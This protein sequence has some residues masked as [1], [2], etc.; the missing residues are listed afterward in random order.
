MK[1][2]EATARD[3]FEGRVHYQIPAYQRPYVW[4]EEDQWSPLWTDVVRVATALLPPADPRAVSAHFLGAVVIEPR[5]DEANYSRNFVIDGQQRMTTMQVLLD[6]VQHV[7]DELGHHQA[8]EDL[9]ELVLNHATRYAGKPERFKLWPSAADR[10]SFEGAM[11]PATGLGDRGHNIQLAHEFFRVEARKWITGVENEE[12]S[13]ASPA[14]RATAL[15]TALQSKLV[16]IAI[17]LAGSD[18]PQVIFET[19]NDRGTPLLKA[20]LIK[21]WV[22][23]EGDRVGADV[24]TWPTRFWSTFDE[25]WWRDEIPQGRRRRSRIDIFLQYWL[26]M[27]LRRDVTSDD[28]FRLFRSHASEAFQDILT[29]EGFLAELLRDAQT[30]RNF[31]EFSPTSAAGRFFSR[32]VET[33]E[34]GATSPVLLWFLSDNHG[35]PESQ[36]EIGLGSLESWVVRRTLTR[37]TMKGVNNLMVSALTR[38]DAAGP[39]QAGSELRTFL[40]EQSAD[41]RDWPTD[42]QVI[43]AVVSLPVYG[44]IRQ[45]RVVMLLRSVERRLV[46]SNPKVEDVQIVGRF[47]LEHV[48]PRGWRT[49][50]NAPPLEQ[51]DASRRD[52]LIH[53]LGN[54]TLVTSSLNGSLS[55]R[56]WN[57]SDADGLVEGGEPNRGKRS[58][59]A[60]FSTLM[61]NKEI[62]DGHADSWTNSDIELRSRLLATRIVEL[63]SGPLE[64]VRS[65]TEDDG[66][67]PA[68]DSGLASIPWTQ[69]DVNR[70]AEECGEATLAV[71]DHLA[72]H[73]EEWFTNQGLTQEI[74]L[75]RPYAAVGALTNK[76]RGS[77]RR[78]NGP[79]MFKEGM[80]TWAWQVDSAFAEQW[81]KARSRQ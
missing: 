50:W 72:D 39:D 7:V 25:T 13:P 8:A 33:L 54:L 70:L 74:G 80:G 53:T 55:N 15:A 30:F 47:E 81:R 73:A 44:W 10:D 29:A 67:P 37:K 76:V 23:Q 11:D 52:R 28:T 45:N 69:E 79:I 64:E 57:D 38:L 78:S 21:N 31:A 48:M 62:I 59:L 18:D 34:I 65:E 4:T 41:A 16:V 35:V 71:L 27:R 6:A 43:D 14:E 42:T 1:A 66:P 60:K 22:F 20:D 26:T 63:W 75:D 24:E 46:S 17:N 9:E 68:K 56:P 5:S 77:F 36:I 51:E 49:H 2:E 12:A 58:L 32:V 40:S 19:L 3:L 61:L